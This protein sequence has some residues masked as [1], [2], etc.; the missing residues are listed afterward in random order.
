MT[1]QAV[2]AQG[3]ATSGRSGRSA[4][5]IVGVASLVGIAAFLHPLLL[6]IA[7]PLVGAAATGRA[8]EAPIVL[9]ALVGLCLAV[10]LAWIDD[11][12]AGPGGRAK[13]VALL[14]T[15]AAI[16]AALRLVPS[17]AGASPIFALI[18]LAGAVFGSSFGFL[19]GSLTLLISAVLTG[20]IGPWLPFQMLGA[21]WVG[22]TAGWLPRSWPHRW[23]LASLIAFGAGWGFLYGA[24]LNL[25]AWPLAAP[26]LATDAGLYWHP[27]LG[28]AETLRRYGAYYLATSFAH[29]LFRGAGNAL[30][31]ALLGPAVLRTLER[32]RA[33]FGWIAGGEPVERAA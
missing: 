24:I 4:G 11:P 14:G 8:A 17:I 26:G 1:P 32:A 5:W 6:P 28:P 16:D 2:P 21:A 27:G 29:D 19:M 20:G 13:A 9:G 7:R 25:Y 23:R 33:R 15:L 3:R 22:L 18:V 10:S 12:S 31:I 30:L